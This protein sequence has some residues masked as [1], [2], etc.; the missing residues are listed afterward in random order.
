MYVRTQFAADMGGYF[1]E[2]KAH[3]EKYILKRRPE[4]RQWLQSLRDNGK[5]LYVITG[6]HLNRDKIE[7]NLSVPGIQG[8]QEN[9]L[10]KS[11][12]MSP[13]LVCLQVSTNIPL[14]PA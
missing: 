13:R 1:P 14:G 10:T 6:T 8:L 4:F 2:I 12:E 11:F 7:S 5:Y 9:A 3:P